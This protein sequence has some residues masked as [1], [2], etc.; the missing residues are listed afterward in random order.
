MKKGSTD[1]LCPL[2]DQVQI[3][4]GFF[5]IYFIFFPSPGA[6]EE[7]DGPVVE[8]GEGGAEPDSYW[9]R[10][11]AFFRDS[12]VSLGD[13]FSSGINDA[14]CTVHQPDSTSCTSYTHVLAVHVIFMHND[15]AYFPVH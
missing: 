3:V 10:K 8:S 4:M 1:V 13:K 2:L 6:G 7:E 12:T 14:A 15:E 9:K 5:L 11:E